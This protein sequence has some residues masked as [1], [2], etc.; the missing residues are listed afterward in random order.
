MKPIFEVGTS[1]EGRLS[2]ESVMMIRLLNIVEGT[3]ATAN[4]EMTETTVVLMNLFPRIAIGMTENFL[5]QQN[6]W[7]EENMTFLMV[8]IIAG[9]RGHMMMTKRMLILRG[10]QHP[11]N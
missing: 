6:F 7:F 2:I 4:Q 9:I 8:T 3:P 5:I 10:T 1:V 11:D